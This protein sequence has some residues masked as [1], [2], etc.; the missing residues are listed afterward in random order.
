LERVVGA[1]ATKKKG[2]SAIDVAL[3]VGQDNKCAILYIVINDQEAGVVAE[4]ICKRSTQRKS[5]LKSVTGL[6]A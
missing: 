5:D 1:L 3:S 2:R 4:E 6:I